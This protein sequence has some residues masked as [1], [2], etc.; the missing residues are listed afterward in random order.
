MSAALSGSLVDEMMNGLTK[1]GA[2]VLPWGLVQD[3]DSPLLWEAVE[4]LRPAAG[5]GR[6]QVPVRRMFGA[7]SPEAL[8]ELGLEVGTTLRR[9]VGA[10]AG[11]LQ[12]VAQRLADSGLIP[13]DLLQQE[14]SW[15]SILA[16]WDA[17]E[18]QRLPMHADWELLSFVVSPDGGLEFEDGEGPR[19]PATVLVAGNLLGRY[20]GSTISPATHAVGPGG[21]RRSL[22]TFFLGNPE[23]CWGHGR[24]GC[25]CSPTLR[26]TMERHYLD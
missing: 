2:A 17:S 26:A 18:A 13:A 21:K 25:T 1:R 16:R 12:Q 9:V 5:E 8:E 24:L 20:S 4:A 22:M 15:S 6:R 19:G 3:L 14:V 11:E 23:A 10:L 7:W